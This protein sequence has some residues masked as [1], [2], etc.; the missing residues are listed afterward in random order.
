MQ[1]IPTPNDALKQ[2]LFWIQKQLGTLQQDGGR[3]WSR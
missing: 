3:G 1:K 2:L